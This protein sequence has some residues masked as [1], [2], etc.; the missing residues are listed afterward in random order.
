MNINFAAI[1]DPYAIDNTG[2]RIEKLNIDNGGSLL[3][4]P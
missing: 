2:R 4:L 1:L 3:R